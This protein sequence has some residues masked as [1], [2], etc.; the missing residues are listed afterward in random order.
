MLK[1]LL[2]HRIAACSHQGWAA[3]HHSF[4]SKDKL[5]DIEEIL[6]L[7]YHINLQNVPTNENSSYCVFKGYLYQKTLKLYLAACQFSMGTNSQTLLPEKVVY[8]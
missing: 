3:C 7:P 2:W 6:E 4:S 5:H 8:L 1:K